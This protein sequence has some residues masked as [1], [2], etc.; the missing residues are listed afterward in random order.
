MP[1][2]TPKSHEQILAGMIARMVSRTNLNDVGDASV[3][4]H[5][6]S[7]AARQDAQQYYQASLLL[8]LFS[9]DTA[10]GEDLDERAKDIQPAT[11]QRLPSAKAVGSVVFTRPGT[12]GITTIPA[13]TKVKTSDGTLFSTTTVGTIDATSPEQV[14]GHGIGRDSNLVAVVADV[15][16]SAGN[17]DAFTVTKF[18]SKPAGISE[19]TNLSA[20][21]QGRDQETDDAFRARLK[22]YVASLA[23]C[24]RSAIENQIIGAQDPDSG[25][26]ILFAKVVEDL[27]NRGNVTVYIDDG[28]GTAESVARSAVA[29]PGTWTWN[30]TL[31]VL[32]TDTSTVAAGDFIRK[33]SSPLVWLQIQSIVPNTSV[34]LLN[35]GGATIPTGAGASSRATDNLTNGLDGPPPNTA[36]GGETTLYTDNKP[37]KDSEPLSVVSSTRGVLVLTTDY[38]LN[39]TNGQIDFITPLVTGE[40]VIADYTYFTGLIAYAQKIIDG[41]PN[42]RDNFPGYRAA[43]VY[44]EVDTPQVLL[45][46]IQCTLT[47]KDGYDQD[48]AKTAARQ[49]IKDYVNNLPISGDFVRSELI[50]RIMGIDGI[51]DI[52]LDVPATNITILDDQIARTTDVNI[53]IA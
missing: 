13:G 37:L 5:L 26:T 3:I 2:F 48:E 6:L 47:V 29:L 23:R 28:S 21:S 40:K 27:V 34:T 17:V 46:N 10:A 7:A 38:I 9:I 11:M 39:P 52:D 16:G 45:Q 51:Y 24:N 15:G 22:V 19:V 33:D 50:K 18:G 41:D 20:F 31:T 49:V 4:K 14:T 35:P 30:G 43:G 53:I 42:D 44:V 12:V 1:R 32:A 8:Q 36:V 25:A